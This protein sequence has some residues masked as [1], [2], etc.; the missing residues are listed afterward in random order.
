MLSVVGFLALPLL[1]LHPMLRRRCLYECYGKLF[2]L[3]GIT[4]QCLGETACLFPALSLVVSIEL[5]RIAVI[6]QR[7]F[8]WIFTRSGNFE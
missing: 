8:C 5:T 2:G 7:M 1:E 3:F 4:K 6:P